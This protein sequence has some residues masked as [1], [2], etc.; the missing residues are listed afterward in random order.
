MARS[1]A[2]DG[3]HTFIS[4]MSESADANLAKDSLATDQRGSQRR[5]D[6]CTCR[7]AR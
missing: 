7:L 1:D 5:S 6:H 2:K 3:P 4:A